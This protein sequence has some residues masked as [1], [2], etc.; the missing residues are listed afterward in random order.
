M[1]GFKEDNKKKRTS[2]ETGSFTTNLNL[3]YIQIF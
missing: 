3:L 2:V 1:E